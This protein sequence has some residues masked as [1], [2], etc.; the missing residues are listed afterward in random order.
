MQSHHWF[1]L[2]LIVGATFLVAQYWNPWDY[3]TGGSPG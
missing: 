1:G 2:V 3:V